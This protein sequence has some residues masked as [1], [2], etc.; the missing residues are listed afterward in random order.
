MCVCM[1]T[2]ERCF[3]LI[4]HCQY[5]LA[6]AKRFYFPA[7]RRPCHLACTVFRSTDVNSQN[8]VSPFCGRNITTRASECR[9]KGDTTA[10][11]TSRVAS[12]ATPHP[13]R[14]C[15]GRQ[16]ESSAGKQ[17]EEAGGGHFRPRRYPGGVPGN[18]EGTRIRTAAKLRYRVNS[19][20]TVVYFVRIIL[21]PVDF[22]GPGGDLFTGP[23]VKHCQLP[24]IQSRR[25]SSRLNPNGGPGPPWIR[26]VS[27]A[28]H[29]S[30][31]APTTTTRK[32]LVDCTAASDSRFLSEPRQAALVLP[33][34][35]FAARCW[36][37]ST[38]GL[39]G[40]HRVAGARCRVPVE[41][42]TACQ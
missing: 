19:F 28:F 12:Y 21:T 29:P 41:G 25:P 18:M 33:S 37:G 10:T 38:L 17:E 7:F 24:R 34:F 4:E 11:D 1:S 6:R 35:I 31:V 39:E 14:M 26:S 30:S 16:P 36:H 20:T 42:V 5:S 2:N 40:V 22:E 3:L 23:K 13:P 8:I 15:T 27:V 32:T 9:R